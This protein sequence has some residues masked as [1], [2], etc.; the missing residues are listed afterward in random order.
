MSVVSDLVCLG[1]E[2]VCFSDSSRLPTNGVSF[3]S[4]HVSI[5]NSQHILPILDVFL[6]FAIST[7]SAT[8][9]LLLYSCRMTRCVTEVLLPER[10]PGYDRR[11][12]YFE[13]RMRQYMLNAM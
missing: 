10:L 5:S 4:S 13:G 12:R 9:V 8:L 3:H 1:H 11:K 2:T 6:T 7:A